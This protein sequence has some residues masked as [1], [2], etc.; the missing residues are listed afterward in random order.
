M[1]PPAPVISPAA[2]LDT[3][4]NDPITVRTEGTAAEYFWEVENGPSFR[5]GN[6]YDLFFR[7]SPI[8][9]T[10][11]AIS[12]DG[13]VS[14]PASG[15]VSFF[16][17]PPVPFLQ[18]KEASNLLASSFTAGRHFWYFNDELVQITEGRFYTPEA[19]GFYS[20][21]GEGPACLSA[22]SQ[23]VSITVTSLAE[24]N[25]LSRRVTLTPNPAGD[26][27]TIGLPDV[28]RGGGNDGLTTV[29]LWSMTGAR[30]RSVELGSNQTSLDLT[31]IRSGAY[32]LTVQRPSLPVVRKRLVR[33]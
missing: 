12:A 25:E 16:R 6:A 14:Q 33:M 4:A 9:Y 10:V 7:N 21:R 5:G 27:V 24:V 29:T 31:G 23:L 17:P 20:V 15:R 22:S 26:F 30:V 18:Y 8:N 28:F 32:L 11:Q 3:C 19:S 13:C 2:V 1:A